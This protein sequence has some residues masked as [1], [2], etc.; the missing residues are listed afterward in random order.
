MQIQ[1]GQDGSLM[2]GRWVSAAKNIL[3]GRPEPWRRAW[4]QLHGVEI[5]EVR[6][7]RREWADK[8]EALAIAPDLSPLAA[9]E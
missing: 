8:L 3:A 5:E 4:L 9:A 6:R 1:I 2:V 7:C